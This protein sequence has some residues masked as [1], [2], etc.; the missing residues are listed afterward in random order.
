MGRLT[1]KGAGS[2]LVGVVADFVDP[3]D[4]VDA[5]WE[6]G[7]GTMKEYSALERREWMRMG[8]RKF[9]DRA[10][11]MGNMTACVA[12]RDWT[13]AVRLFNAKYPGYELSTKPEEVRR[14]RGT[15]NLAE[16]GGR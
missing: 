10:M 3:V 12:R 4:G 6:G 1:W 13:A 5:W 7:E 2:E 11:E 14:E 8:W 9:F 15:L 16:S